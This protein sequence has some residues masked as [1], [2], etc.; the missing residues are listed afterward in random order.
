MKWIWKYSPIGARDRKASQALTDFSKHVNY[1]FQ[2]TN[3][4]L[5]CPDLNLR[6]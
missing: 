2:I 5:F 3:M 1:S 4:Y 6:N